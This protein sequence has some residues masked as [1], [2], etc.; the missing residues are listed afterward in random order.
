VKKEGLAV[1]LGQ[2]S[3]WGQPKGGQGGG[4]RLIQ[5]RQS[6]S[7]ARKEFREEGG[8]F[9]EHLRS[10]ELLDYLHSSLF[11]S[12]NGDAS[13]HTFWVTTMLSSF[14]S[15]DPEEG[16]LSNR[17]RFSLPLLPLHRR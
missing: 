11:A 12:V 8:S 3:L 16:A 17:R 13:C 1:V 5:K 7:I 14:A 9:R 4:T 6:K 15:L 2:E 10:I